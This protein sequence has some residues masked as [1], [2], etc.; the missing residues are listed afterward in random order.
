MSEQFEVYEWN[1]K[2]EETW[3]ER[4]EFIGRKSGLK[5]SRYCNYWAP[6]FRNFT[7]PSRVYCHGRETIK[8]KGAHSVKLLLCRA[9]LK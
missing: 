7:P 2:E 5:W 3:F 1:E 8:L 6:P 9:W 4:P